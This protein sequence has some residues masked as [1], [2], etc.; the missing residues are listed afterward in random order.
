ML[1]V[2][3]HTAVAQQSHKMQL[4]RPPALHRLLKQRYVLQLLVRNQQV[5]P[6]NVHV[7]DPPRAHVH[8]PDFTVAHLAFG[9]SNI[10]PG[11]MDQGVGKFLDQPVIRRLPCE[12]NRI[13]LRLRA[14]S[15]PIE[16]SQHN[17][18][19]SFCHSASEYTQSFAAVIPV[20]E[21]FSGTS[22]LVAFLKGAHRHPVLWSS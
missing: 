15:P 5:D 18:F 6:G 9:Q 4:P 21:V 3:V 13:P 17:W 22:P 7:H 10:R 2:R 16:H 20:L 8:V 1:N 14:V 11:R 12:R 19:R